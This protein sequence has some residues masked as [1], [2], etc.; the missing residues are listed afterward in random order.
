MTNDIKAKRYNFDYPKVSD[1][2]KI[3]LTS[4]S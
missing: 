2:G 1:Y 4:A 3:K